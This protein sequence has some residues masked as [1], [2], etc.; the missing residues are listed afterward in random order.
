VAVGSLQQLLRVAGRIYKRTLQARFPQ[1]TTTTK[2]RSTRTI[3]NHARRVVTKALIEL[4]FFKNKQNIKISLHI[5][6]NSYS[7]VN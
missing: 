6:I 4:F 3:T 7:T 5:K 1:E 2:N